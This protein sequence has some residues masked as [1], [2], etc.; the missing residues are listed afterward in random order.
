M[1]V[2]DDALARHMTETEWLGR[3]AVMVI[4]ASAMTSYQLVYF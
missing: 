1:I 3:L 4:G 2:L